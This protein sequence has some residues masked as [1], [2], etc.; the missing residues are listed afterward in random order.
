[1]H[2][3]YHQLT[4]ETSLHGGTEQPT[5]T[6]TGRTYVLAGIVDP[7]SRTNQHEVIGS[8]TLSCTMGYPTRPMARHV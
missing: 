1:M 2:S 4:L 8:L 5:P 6:C 7:R 3:W